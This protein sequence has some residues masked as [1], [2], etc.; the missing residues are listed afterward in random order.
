MKKA[1]LMMPL[2]MAISATAAADNHPGLE[3]TAGW[4][5]MN[6]DNHRE[7]KAH[8][9]WMGAIGY[10]MD[11]PWGVEFG[12][13]QNNPSMKKTLQEIETTQY[14][15][16]GLYHF[17]TEA[18][19][20]PFVMAGVGYGHFKTDTASD[21]D[22]ALN[23]GVG[24]KGYLTDN[25]L[26]RADTRAIRGIADG[27]IDYALNL[28]ATY[29]IGTG[30][31]KPAPVAMAAAPSDA[32]ADGVVDTQD[33]CPQTPAGVKVD[34]RGCAL[35]S[36]RD[37]VADYKDQCP[38]TE[39]GL[40][41]DAKG[42]AIELTEAVEIKLHVRFDNNAAVVKPEYKSE[43]GNVAKFMNSYANT[44]VE[45]QGFTDSRG[46]EAYNQNLS[47]RRADAVRSV[48]ISEFGIAPERVKAVGYGEAN[49]VADNNTAE[50]REANRRV[51]ASIESQKTS[52]VRK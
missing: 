14:Y 33:A 21:R 25:F 28:A 1:W 11:S 3:L 19:I 8:S 40:K 24:V 18:D 26:L 31:S 5:Q 12:M 17:N 39:A 4:N 34:S 43:I 48:L 35:D 36:D 51:V 15:L 7:M 49:P 50:G 32:D 2:A 20:Q 37:G 9:G 22:E 23:I 41:V 47:Q 38:N 45:V 42:C 13:I 29:L 6:W 27:D 30:S 10:R 16:D 44:T 46:S 52:K